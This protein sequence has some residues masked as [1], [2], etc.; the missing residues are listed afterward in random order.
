MS[1]KFAVFSG[2]S[3]GRQLADWAEDKA[4]E[5]DFIFFVATEYGGEMMKEHVNIDVRQGRL[6]PDEM[7]DILKSENV[8]FVIDATHPYATKVTENIKAAC[9]NEFKY[10]RLYRERIESDLEGLIFA[11]S[12]EDAVKILNNSTEKILLTTGSKEIAKFSNVLDK[13]NRLIARVLPTE[14]S[15]N[16]C[17]DAG[18]EKRNIIAM[19]GPFIKEMNVATMKQYGLTTLVTKDTG[20]VGGFQDKAALS[21]LGYRV[22]IIKRPTDE[23]GYS[24]S[25]IKEIIL[26]NY[27]VH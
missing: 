8:K 27:E 5:K 12:I 24:M 1:K 18:I 11:E 7:H 26:E 16:L 6:T 10:L 3:E 17:L 20:T 21:E 2:T 19:Q 9:K 25:E 22:I 13:E 4:I 23:S 15:I 14:E